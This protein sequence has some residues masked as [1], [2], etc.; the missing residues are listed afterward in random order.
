MGT[1][2]QR[3]NTLRMLI[4]GFKY[5]NLDNNHIDTASLGSIFRRL[6]EDFPSFNRRKNDYLVPTPEDISYLIAKLVEPKEEDTIYDPTVGSGSLLIKVAEEIESKKFYLYAQEKNR[7]MYDLCKMN[8]IINGMFNNINALEWKDTFANPLIKKENNELMKFKVIV[9][10]IPFF[11]KNWWKSET[12]PMLDTCNRFHKEV[13]K[14]NKGDYAFISHIVSTMDE[15]DGRAAVIV[16]H[17][18]LFRI[19]IE[20]DI[21]KDLIEEDLIEAVIGLP[22]NLLYS[23]SIPVSIII[24]NKKRKRKGILFIDASK[25]FINNRAKNKLSEDN[26]RKIVTTYKECKTEIRYSSLIS[27]EEI[28]KNDYNLNIT[29]Y[30]DTFISTSKKENVNT[31]DINKEIASLEKEISETQEK[32]EGYLSE[33]IKLKK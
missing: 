13:S 19:G 8:I 4:E 29:R 24:F 23:T 10:H 26:I 30:I 11:E 16:P 31:D 5:I 25:D 14:L 20:A 21:R 7:N 17:G 2:D 12:D 28:R 9:S 6:I 18:V 15:Q 27:K 33:L 1:I 32:L 22:S 3:N